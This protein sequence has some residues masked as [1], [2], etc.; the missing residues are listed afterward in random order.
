MPPRDRN[1][2]SAPNSMM[3]NRT[4][5]RIWKTNGSARKISAGTSTSAMIGL[6][7]LTL[8]RISA[9]TAIQNTQVNARQT[10]NLVQSVNLRRVSR[11]VPPNTPRTQNWL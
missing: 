9:R 6:V 1:Q 2:N 11:S 5:V 10:R 7:P 8:P 3:T 4:P